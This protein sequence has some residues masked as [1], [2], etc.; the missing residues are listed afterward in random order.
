VEDGSA[1]LWWD[2]LTDNQGME[3]VLGQ[4]ECSGEDV[5]QLVGEHP[6]V[7]YDSLVW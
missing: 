2:T 6:H 1:G 7:Q 4:P 5:Q 3:G